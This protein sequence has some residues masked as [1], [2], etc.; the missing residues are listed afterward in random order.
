MKTNAMMLCLAGPISI[1]LLGGDGTVLS[2]KKTGSI[3]TAVMA[4]KQNPD[5]EAEYFC[6]VTAQCPPVGCPQYKW[7]VSGGKITGETT[8]PNVRIDVHQVAA[9]TLK[10]ICKVTWPKSPPLESILLTKMINLR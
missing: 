7:S 1:I 6:N 10:V 9:G 3:P 8:L 4:C 5:N 2:Q